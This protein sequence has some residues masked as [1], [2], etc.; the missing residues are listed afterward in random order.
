MIKTKQPEKKWTDKGT[1]FKG[2]FKTLCEE[3][4]IHLFTTENETKSAFAERIIRS[5]LNIINRYLEVKWTWNYIK[6]LPNFL[7]IIN[8]RVNR[9]KKLAPNKVF[10]KHGPFL[11]SIALNNNKYKPRFEEGDLVR[12]AKTRRYFQKRLISEAYRRSF[13][14]T[15]IG[16]NKSTYIQSD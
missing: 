2:K 6:E 13:H 15:T 1:E 9:V 12:I 3:K 11:I 8:S 4:K 16:Y 7:N 10:K 14:S 5:L